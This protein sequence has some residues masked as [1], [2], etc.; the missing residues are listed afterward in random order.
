MER[1]F[2]YFNL[3]KRVF[4]IRALTGPNKGCIIA[5]LPN[6][7]LKQ[8]RFKVSQ[9]GRRRVLAERR[10]N[11]HAGVV[12]LWDGVT[13]TAD[14]TIRV[15]YNPYDHEQFVVKETQE[16]I[17]E[18]ELAVLVTAPHRMPQIFI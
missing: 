15:T 4:S 7:V 9:A 10:K 11:V 3:H 14:A 2:V 18:S 12:G 13:T 1:V 6:M 5:H 8:C 17:Y 16:P